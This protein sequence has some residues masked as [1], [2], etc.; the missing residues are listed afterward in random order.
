M[1]AW[2]R[3]RHER[4]FQR[5]LISSWFKLDSQSV[6]DATR[7]VEKAWGSVENFG[8]KVLDTEI[9]EVLTYNDDLAAVIIKSDILLP[10]H[11]YGA[12]HFGR[13]KG[14]WKNLDWRDGEYLSPNVAAAEEDFGKRK[15]NRWQA[16][17]KMKDDIEHGRTV[18][19]HIEHQPT[20]SLS[21]AEK[22]DNKRWQTRTWRIA[23][24]LDMPSLEPP[25]VQFAV[26]DNDPVPAYAAQVKKK[27]S[28]S[29]QELA[30]ADNDAR[31]RQR[32]DG[33]MAVW[34]DIGFREVTAD[35][36]WLLTSSAW[37]PV[38][39]HR[40]IRQARWQEVG[41]HQDCANRG[42]ALCAGASRS[43]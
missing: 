43:R 40:V 29:L 15:D 4:T 5:P 42:K 7:D 35:N 37:R 6:K 16:F 25:A 38:R 39:Q 26:L 2:T 24:R 23:I 27:K 19:R 22:E 3:A 10:G 18:T 33:L 1:A 9:V 34:W 30:K 36:L 13:I 31:K 8:Q 41:R 21:A 28:Y 12:Q 11:Q 20:P 32:R 17:V 14:E